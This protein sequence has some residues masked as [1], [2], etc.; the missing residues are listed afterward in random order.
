MLYQRVTPRNLAK[1]DK[2]LKNH[3]YIA[4]GRINKLSLWDQDIYLKE[5]TSSYAVL[6]A[7]IQ[8]IALDVT[9]TLVKVCLLH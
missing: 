4:Q 8:W 2:G 6:H 3:N 7:K 5:I 1:L 9:Y